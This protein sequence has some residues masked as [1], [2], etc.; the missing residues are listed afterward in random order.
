MWD[1]QPSL[2]VISFTDV[3]FSVGVSLVQDS[4]NKGACVVHITTS[5][6]DCSSRLSLKVP[7][8]FHVE[9]VFVYPSRK[10]RIA[11]LVVTIHEFGRSNYHNNWYKWGT[12]RRRR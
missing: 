6:D 5:I 3:S 1:I 12:E 2:I 4:N 9:R 10:E 11:S 7:A 8:R